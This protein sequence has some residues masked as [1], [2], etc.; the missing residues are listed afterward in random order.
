[1]QAEGASFCWVRRVH[2]LPNAVLN[3]IGP[4]WNT[5]SSCHL[6]LC[7]A[8]GYIGSGVAQIMVLAS[9]L[10]PTLLLSTWSLIMI[11]FTNVAAGRCFEY[12]LAFFR[13]CR[14]GIMLSLL[15]SDTWP[16]TGSSMWMSES[17]WS[18]Y[19]GLVST[20][21][22]RKE[23]RAQDDI[24]PSPKHNLLYSTSNRPL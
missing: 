2:R 10:A 4:L 3:L 24:L 8:D 22:A 11:F 12:R 9:N 16:D 14:Y 15:K 19:V 7:G 17:A 5:P 1:M 18:I 20:A 6:E 21:S 13:S 23:G